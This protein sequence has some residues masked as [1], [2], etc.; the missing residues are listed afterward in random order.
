MVTNDA[1]NTQTLTINSKTV[2]PINASAMV[3]PKSTSGV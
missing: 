2:K 3:I 1:N